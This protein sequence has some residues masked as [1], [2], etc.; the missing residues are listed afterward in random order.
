MLPL[1]LSSFSPVLP[2]H[3]L[4][5]VGPFMPPC[6]VFLRL[7]ALWGRDLMNF[8]CLLCGRDLVEQDNNLCDHLI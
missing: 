1:F 5:G 4:P 7:E 6:L 2:P 3:L 8:L